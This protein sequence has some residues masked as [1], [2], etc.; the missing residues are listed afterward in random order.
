MKKT[1]IIITIT[2]S[3]ILTACVGGNAVNDITKFEGSDFSFSY[4]NDLELKKA[5][6]TFIFRNIDGDAV[7][8]MNR[9]IADSMESVMEQI[10]SVGLSCTYTSGGIKYGGYKAYTVKPDNGGVCPLEGSIISNKKDMY[11]LF[12]V[13]KK[14]GTQGLI[15]T[16]KSTFRFN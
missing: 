5:A 15:D 8:T 13:N 11:V 1:I 9:Y 10:Q 4:P 14:D 16:L 7:L 6:T 2:L 12:V 3:F